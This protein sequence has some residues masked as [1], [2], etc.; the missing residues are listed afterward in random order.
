MCRCAQILGG[1]YVEG[2]HMYE[3]IERLAHC[4]VESHSLYSIISTRLQLF[5]LIA[6]IYFIFLSFFH[7]VPLIKNAA[8][9]YLHCFWRTV[10]SKSKKKKK[11]T[12]AYEKVRRI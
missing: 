8:Y 6:N 9:G 12:M 7:Y 1:A 2:L 11:K 3:N 5:H 4:N 10:V